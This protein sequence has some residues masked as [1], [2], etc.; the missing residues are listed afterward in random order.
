MRQIDRDLRG[1]RPMTG[2]RIHRFECMRHL[3]PFALEP[4]LAAPEDCSIWGCIA[5]PER[6]L[7]MVVRRQIWPH[8]YTA[9][10]APPAIE[11]DCSFRGS[12]SGLGPVDLSPKGAI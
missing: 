3:A 7:P 6:P 8:R 5:R 9:M 12:E 1:N 4:N 10:Y 2:W 11:E